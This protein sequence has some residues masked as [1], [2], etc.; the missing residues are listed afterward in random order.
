[1]IRKA[2]QADRKDAAV[3]LY[4]ALHDIAVKL[5]GGTTKE[6][7]LQGLE[8]WFRQPDNRLSYEN[9]L[10]EQIDGH[11]VGIIVLYHG[12]E[13]EKLDAPIVKKL[14]RLHNDPSIILEKEAEYDEY[15]IDTLSVHPDY[16]GQ[17]IGTSLIRAAEEA[18]RARSYTKIS[19]LVEITN[20]RAFSLYKRIGYTQ[21]KIVSLIGEPF[22]HLTKN[23]QK[24]AQPELSAMLMKP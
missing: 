5:T 17:G 21:D 6:E 15:Y 20:D 14:R 4:N 11:V 16:E 13:A 22:A 10:V 8:Y 3:L 7:V 9:C 24:K 23:I 19:I 2:V 18:A 1:M 12:S